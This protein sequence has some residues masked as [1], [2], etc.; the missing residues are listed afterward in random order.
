VLSKGLR[1]ADI[2]DSSNEIVSTQ[3]MGKAVIEE[4]KKLS[5]N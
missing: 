3:E 2:N 4:L 1:T 5:G